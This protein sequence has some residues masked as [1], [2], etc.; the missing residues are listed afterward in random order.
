MILSHG[1]A[2][3]IHH[4]NDWL[5]CYFLHGVKVNAVSY[6]YTGYGEADGNIPTETSIY[7]DISA[8]YGYLTQ[9]LRVDPSRILL[10]G[11]S[12]GSGP[13]CWLSEKYEVAG[14]ILHSAIMSA[15]RVIIRTPCTLIGDKFPNINRVPNINCPIFVIHG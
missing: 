5:E 1:N 13:S 3:D 6:E 8:V 9:N 10:Y 2:E 11:R 12:I 4:V 15:F 14:L 7:N